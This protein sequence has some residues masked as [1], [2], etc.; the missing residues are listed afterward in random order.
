MD[1]VTPTASTRG[2]RPFLEY[3]Y[4]K[5]GLRTEAVSSNG[6]RPPWAPPPDWVGFRNEVALQGD[7]IAIEVVKFASVDMTVS[8]VGIYRHAP[9][10]IYGDRQN[11]AGVG[12]WL[13][14]V[15]PSEPALLLAGLDS[16][17]SLLQKSEPG[18][19]TDKSTAF[20]NDYVEG[21]LARYVETSEPLRGLK[22]ADSPMLKTVGYAVDRASPENKDAVADL[23]FRSFFMTPRDEQ[24]SRALILVT[25]IDS[26]ESLTSQGYAR[27]TNTRFVAELLAKLP[28]AFETQGAEVFSLQQA[29]RAER[30]K[31]DEL[32]SRVNRLTSDLQT[33][34]E[35]ASEFERQCSDLRS[36]LEGNDEH[37]RHAAILQKFAESNS[38]LST[39]ARGISHL[40][41]DLLADLRSEFRSAVN[42]AQSSTRNVS[43][44]QDLRASYRQEAQPNQGYEFYWGRIFFFGLIILIVLGAVGVGIYYI[45]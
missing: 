1:A 29:L 7:E 4:Y 23:L 17:L 45:W 21:Y 20:L 6:I 40:R 5:G 18:E 32:D 14:A 11:H 28:K 37:R 9:D 42:F 31:T 25:G 36:S 13:P 19:F 44:H 24:A 26:V 16:L 34:M 2:A 33:A 43:A 12:V 27:H 3:H 8:W 22:A 41:H 15:F 10:Q 39:V 30:V 38:H 35:S